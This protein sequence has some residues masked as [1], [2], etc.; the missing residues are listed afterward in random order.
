VR[1]FTLTESKY[2]V[3]FV[4][5][6]IPVSSDTPF[7]RFYSEAT[8]APLQALYMLRQI[9]PFV[10]CVFMSVFQYDLHFGQQEV[11]VRENPAHLA[12]DHHEC[13]E[14]HKQQH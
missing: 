10:N 13:L 2:F 9:C 6:R 1:P 11:L 4:E 8:L 14:Q 5:K 7:L 12:G 3:Y